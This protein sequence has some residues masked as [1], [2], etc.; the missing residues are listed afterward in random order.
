MI[1]YHLRFLDEATATAVLFDDNIVSGET[2]AEVSSVAKVPR[3][4]AVDVIGTIYKPTGKMLTSD[5]GPVE[6]MAPVPGW[7]VNVRHSEEAPELASFIIQVKT[8][9]RV[10]L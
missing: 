10:W 4:L 2:L 9:C 1:D 8:P 3:Y 7:H 6:E 5:E